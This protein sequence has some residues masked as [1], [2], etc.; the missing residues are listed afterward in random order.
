MAP[1]LLEIYGGKISQKW[2]WFNFEEANN[3]RKWLLP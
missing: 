3:E 2:N 1:L